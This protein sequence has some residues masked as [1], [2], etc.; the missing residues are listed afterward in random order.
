[1]NGARWRLFTNDV[2]RQGERVDHLILSG[3]VVW[4][5]YV[6]D[7]NCLLATRYHRALENRIMISENEKKGDRRRKKPKS[8][9]SI[10]ALIV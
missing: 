5:M 6:M 4:K 8:H 10:S 7:K 3:N 2:K 1:M 9:D